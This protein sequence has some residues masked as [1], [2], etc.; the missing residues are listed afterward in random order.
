MLLGF[1][2]I[3]SEKTVRLAMSFGGHCESAA[4]S[5]NDKIFFTRPRSHESG[6]IYEL[7]AYIAVV[8]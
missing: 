6:K 1:S 4:E 2:S 7:H 3:Q 8:K 5:S